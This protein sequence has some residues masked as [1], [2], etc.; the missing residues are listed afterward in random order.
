[1]IKFGSQVDR[2]L[3]LASVGAICVEERDALKPG[4]TIVCRG[5]VAPRTV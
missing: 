4:E 3:P 2:F 1:M 5:D